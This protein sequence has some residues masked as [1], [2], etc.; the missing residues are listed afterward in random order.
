MTSEIVEGL[1]LKGSYDVK[2]ITEVSGYIISN[3]AFWNIQNIRD[4]NNVYN[5][6]FRAYLEGST[7]NCAKM[8]SI[9]WNDDEDITAVETL[10]ALTS[11][12]AQYYDI[13]G[14]K[15]N[16]LQQGINIVKRGNK[17]YKIIVK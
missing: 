6:P 5:A 10:D 4:G 13:N 17:T 16:D 15:L 7:A 11:D 14:R 9:G 1:T 3:N 8:L 12:E 2:D